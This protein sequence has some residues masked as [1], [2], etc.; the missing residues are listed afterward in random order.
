MVPT[1]PSRTT[2]I[3]IDNGSSAEVSVIQ[4]FLPSFCVLYSS[5]H[6][7]MGRVDQS[8]WAHCAVL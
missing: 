7:G 3:N 4:F 2:L 1:Y 6:H 5:R 8:L